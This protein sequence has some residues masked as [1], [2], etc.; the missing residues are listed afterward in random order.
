MVFALLHGGALAA[1]F[2]FSWRACAVAVFLHWM[3]TGLGI[4]MGYHRLHTHR[5]YQVPLAL[6]YFFAAVLSHEPRDR[7]RENA[8]VV[9][10]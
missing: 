2:A 8:L 9:S 6:E 7:S 5:S 4:S 3:S 10:Y 1:L